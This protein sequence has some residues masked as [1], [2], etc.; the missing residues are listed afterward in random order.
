[1]SADKGKGKSAGAPATD[2]LDEGDVLNLVLDYL[3]TKGFVEAE[4]TLRQSVSAAE[5]SPKKHSSNQQ[6]GVRCRYLRHWPCELR[7]F[8]MQVIQ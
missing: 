6:T 1:M 5:G 4:K 2:R 7:S 8:N 3:A